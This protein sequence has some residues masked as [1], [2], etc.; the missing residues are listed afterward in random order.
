MRKVKLAN[1]P[2]VRRASPTVTL[3][4]LDMAVVVVVVVVVIVIG[5]E[6]GGGGGTGRRG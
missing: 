2:V 6:G 3:S 1:R 4:A 5:G